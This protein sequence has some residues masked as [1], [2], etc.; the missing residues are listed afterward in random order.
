MA[1]DRNGVELKPG[2]EFVIRG[3]VEQ[4]FPTEENGLLAVSY[5][6]VVPLLGYVKAEAVEKVEQPLESEA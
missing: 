1:I 2:D 4:V 3:R 5:Q 6:T